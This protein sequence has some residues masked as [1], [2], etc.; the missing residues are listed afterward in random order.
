MA[1]ELAAWKLIQ[2]L[3]RKFDFKFF[4]GNVQKTQNSI[5]LIRHEYKWV[6]KQ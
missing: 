6:M 2:I 3:N 1:F 5:S 4:S